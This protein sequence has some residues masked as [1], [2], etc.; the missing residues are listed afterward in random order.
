MAA[1]AARRAVRRGG[2]A[3]GQGP[4]GGRGPLGRRRLADQRRG[5]RAG[6]APAAVAAARAAHRAA[7]GRRLD[8]GVAVR[9][10]LRPGAA[11]GL[12]DRRPRRAA[13]GPSADD[14]DEAAELRTE[15]GAVSR[16]SSAGGTDVRDDDGTRPA[17]VALTW[18]AEPGN[19]SGAPAGPPVRPGRG[20]RAGSLAG[21]DP[22]TPRCARAVAARLAA[23][24]PARG[25]RAG[26]RAE[27]ER[28]G[29]RIA[30]PDDRSGRPGWTTWFGSTASTPSSRVDRGHAPAAVPLGARRLAAGRGAGPVGRGRRRAGQHRLRRPRGHRAGLR[31][32][33]AGLDRGLRRRV[34]HRRRRPPGRAGR[35]RRHRRGARLRRRPAVPGGQH[36]PVRPDRR[37]R[38]ADQR[39]AARRRAAPAPLPDPQPGDRGR[40]PSAPWWSRRPPAAAPRQTLRRAIA[41][42]RPAMVV[43]G[44]VTSAMSVGCHETAARAAGPGPAGRPGCPT[45]WRRSAA[46]GRTWRRCRA[47][48]STRATRST[49]SGHGAGGGARRRRPVGP[50]R[51]RR[52]GGRRAAHRAAQARPAARELGLLRQVRGGYALPPRRR[53]PAPPRD[54]ASPRDTAPPHDPA[55]PRDTAPPPDPERPREPP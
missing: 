13:T 46:S 23:G 20:A 33:R 53:N 24:D 29:A 19:R 26:A 41:L 25:G 39:V 55:P 37:D 7:C 40:H 22:A 28:L 1:G 54:T 5:A 12:D 51:D 18:L 10:R 47:A 32:G 2:R 14:V 42:R 35:R 11:P 17:R 6:A 45:C 48:R 30:V 15:A 43:P 49:P 4:G 27:R 44:P 38:P 52:P 21:D 36:R 31:A 16:A 3:G 8:S 50:G 34:R 9:P